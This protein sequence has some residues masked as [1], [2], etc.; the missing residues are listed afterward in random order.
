MTTNNSLCYSPEVSLLRPI[1]NG[2]FALW[3]DADIKKI[4]ID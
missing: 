4:A 3:W 2:E 1:A